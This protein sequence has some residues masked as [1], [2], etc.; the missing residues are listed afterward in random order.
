MFSLSEG[1]IWQDLRGRHSNRVFDPMKTR[2]ACGS[3]VHVDL[4][5]QKICIMC[6]FFVKQDGFFH[7]AGGGI[8]CRVNDRVSRVI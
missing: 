8:S 7:P 2:F 4:V 5:S 6:K 3:I 1:F